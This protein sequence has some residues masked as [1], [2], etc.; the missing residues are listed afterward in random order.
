MIEYIGIHKQNLLFVFMN[1]EAISYNSHLCA[2]IFRSKL[3]YHLT[4]A[5]SRTLVVHMCFE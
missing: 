4:E 1:F 5:K 2:R 3:N